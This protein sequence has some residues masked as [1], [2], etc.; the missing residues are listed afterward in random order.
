MKIIETD[1]HENPIIENLQEKKAIP[2]KFYDIQEY[3]YLDE[4]TGKPVTIYYCTKR[5]NSFS[6]QDLID[7]SMIKL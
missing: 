6:I 7:R 4:N 3:C 2:A 1:Q 5:N